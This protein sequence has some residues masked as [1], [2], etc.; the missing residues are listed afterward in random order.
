MSS[1]I[2]PNIDP[3]VVVATLALAAILTGAS[4]HA[5]AQGCANPLAWQWQENV[6]LVIDT[7]TGA[8]VNTGF[9]GGQGSPGPVVSVALNYNPACMAISR[10]EISGGGP[11]FDPVMYLSNDRQ[12]C[13]QG[14]CIGFADTGSPLEW[15]GYAEG[16]YTL[17]VTARE[18]NSLNACG[19]VSL[20]L[21]GQ[22]RDCSDRIFADRFDQTMVAPLPAAAS[23]LE[24]A[25]RRAMR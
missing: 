15:V 21:I 12:N 5:G 25:I 19:V 20:A 11:G 13:A 22:L 24:D 9:C 6:P 14:T 3:R 1:P 2:A 8:Q 17:N 16:D 23:S 4:V 18:S 7:C 10:I